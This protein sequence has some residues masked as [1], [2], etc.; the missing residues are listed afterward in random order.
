MKDLQRQLEDA[1][2]TNRSLQASAAADLEGEQWGASLEASRGSQGQGLAG[3]GGLP[4]RLSPAASTP[5]MPVTP[6]VTSD[7]E[8]YAESVSGAEGEVSCGPGCCGGG[9]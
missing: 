7:M 1:G 9:H 2:A 6:A 5:S 4:T 3:R 8:I